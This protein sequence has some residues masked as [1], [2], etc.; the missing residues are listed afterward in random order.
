M[1]TISVKVSQIRLLAN[2][3]A[4]SPAVLVLGDSFTEGI[5]RE[6]ALTDALKLLPTC[7]HK[8]V[9]CST[10]L[11]SECIVADEGWI[12]SD[13]VSVL[14]PIMTAVKLHCF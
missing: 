6:I 7:I 8:A 3:R 10:D 13:V 5:L 9:F 1:L 4:C 2:I 14:Y 11:I 12:P